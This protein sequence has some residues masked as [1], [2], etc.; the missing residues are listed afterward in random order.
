MSLIPRERT[1][2]LSLSS[3]AQRGHE[4]RE[5]V[6][7]EMKQLCYVIEANG[8]QPNGSITMT[9]GDLFEVRSRSVLNRCK[10]FFEDLLEYLG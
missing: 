6:L 2:S 9:F 5:Q 3:L 1:L 4:I 10:L 7:E 8:K